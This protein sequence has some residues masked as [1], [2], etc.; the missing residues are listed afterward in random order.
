MT[1]INELVNFYRNNPLVVISA[2]DLW[3]K[4]SE[5][6]PSR[7]G[8]A[9]AKK[10]LIARVP[11]LRF[12]SVHDKRKVFYFSSEKLRQL[13]R[14]LELY[15][16]IEVLDNIKRELNSYIEFIE[17]EWELEYIGAWF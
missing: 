16:D 7:R 10:Q 8:K 1:K 9:W 11:F 15:S 3:A 6:Y 12:R 13:L 4:I 14:N 5:I 2:S 17:L